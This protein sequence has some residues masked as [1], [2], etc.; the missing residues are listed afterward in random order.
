MVVLRM[1]LACLFM[2]GLLAGCPGND[3]DNNQEP[4]ATNDAVTLAEDTNTVISVL[5]ND[6]DDDGDTLVIVAVSTPTNGQAVSNGTN[7]TYT[8][9]ANFN[10]TDTFSYTITDGEGHVATATVA[11]TVT[12]VAEPPQEGAVFVGTNHNNTNADQ[13]TD[14]DNDTSEPA[15]Q[16]VMYHRDTDGNLTLVG[17]FNT[18]GQGSGPGQRFAG[19]GLGSAHS[20]QLSQDRNWLFVANAGSDNI[21][22]FRVLPFGLELVDIEATT[23]DAGDLRFPNSVTQFGDLVYVLSSANEGGITGFRLSAEGNLTP[24][25][26]ST[27]ALNAN[28]AYPPDALLNPVQVSFTP[29]GSQLV[30]TIKDGAVGLDP[31]TPPTGEGRIL[32]FN[33]NAQGLPSANFVQ[34]TV[35]NRGPF[36]FSFDRQGNLLVALF[37][38]GPN[39]TGAAASF[40]INDD[41]TLSAITNGVDAGNQI[42]TC[43]LENNGSYA[44]GANYTSGTISSFTIGDNGSLTLLD[45]T[46]GETEAPVPARTQG[47]TP[48]DLGVSDDG[49]FLYNVLPG[50]GRVAAWRIEA[51]GSLTPIDEFVGLGQTIEGDHAPIDF[52]TGASPAGIAVY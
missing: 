38:G 24:I 49:R 6:A 17:Y 51:N 11:V 25:A 39:L 7:I 1:F 9:N 16:V 34:T 22:V 15:N 40:R 43:W 12:D 19:D 47:S 18:G 14:P 21:S 52:G 28:Q 29:D 35:N 41:G 50:S 26:N 30:V 23:G 48:L 2:L 42:D 20:V 31:Q 46:A 10:G 8:P 44:F 3:D 5:A 36:G 32:V 27:R 33:V 45:A 37:V 13:D 4:V